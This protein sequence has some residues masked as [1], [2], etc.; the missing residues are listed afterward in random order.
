MVRFSASLKV[1]FGTVGLSVLAVAATSRGS[2][3]RSL[4][5]HYEREELETH[6]HYIAPGPED[7]RSPCPA[8]NV[9]ANH[10]YL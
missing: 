3:T 9:L 1:V 7:S 8:L 5:A 2:L 6:H 10:G 4:I